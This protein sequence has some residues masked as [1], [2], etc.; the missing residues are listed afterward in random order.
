MATEYKVVNGTSFDARTPDQV[1]RTLLQYMGTGQRIRVFYGDPKTGRDW[2]EEWGTMGYIGR[3]G[4]SV[5]IPLIINNSRSFG[6]PGLLEGSIVRITVNRR[7]VYIHPKYHIDLAVKGNNVYKNG[8][9]YATC[10]SN[11][12]AKKLAMFLRGDSNT[13]G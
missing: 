13:K 10:K 11:E 9:L 3:S 4:G 5:K 7:N 1:I 8:E 12:K 6:G 2:G